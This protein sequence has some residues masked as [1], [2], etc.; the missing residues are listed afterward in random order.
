METRQAI[1]IFEA[2]SSDVR[3]NAVPGTPKNVVATGQQALFLQLYCPNGAH[4]EEIGLGKFWAYISKLLEISYC[5]KCVQ[6]ST[7]NDIC[8][9]NEECL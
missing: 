6:N 8:S 2:L 3:L 1:T 5:T 9:Y 4:M 7:R